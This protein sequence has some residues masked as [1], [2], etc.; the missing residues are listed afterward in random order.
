MPQDDRVQKFESHI[1]PHLDSAYNLARWLTGNVDD[2]Q[3]VTQEASLR[4]FRFVDSLHG[5]NSRAWLLRIVRNTAYIWLKRRRVEDACVE[6]VEKTPGP[7]E[8]C[9]PAAIALRNVDAAAIRRVLS[10]LPVEAREILLLREVEELAYKE[11]ARV[12]D[13]PIGTVMSRLARARK[14]LRDCLAEEEAHVDL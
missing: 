13:V 7:R 2:A 5:A 4:A 3:D 6:H 12:M 9:D 11:I 1:R 14:L 8:A 10:G